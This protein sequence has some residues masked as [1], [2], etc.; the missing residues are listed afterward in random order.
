MEEEG[1]RSEN[2]GCG[3]DVIW[4]GARL[5]TGGGAAQQ[6]GPAKTSRKEQHDPI[7]PRACPPL[8]LVAGDSRQVPRR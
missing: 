3:T 4:E 6:L 5:E 1:W 7:S 8:A 2:G